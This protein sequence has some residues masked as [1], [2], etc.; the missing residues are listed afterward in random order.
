MVLPLLDLVRRLPL[1]TPRIRR[2]C[3]RDAVSTLPGPRRAANR[4]EVT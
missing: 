1:L 4:M 3:V 2:P